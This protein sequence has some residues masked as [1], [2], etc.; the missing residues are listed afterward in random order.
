MLKAIAIDDEPLA[1]TIISNFSE[2]TEGLK[3]EKTFSSQ[4]HALKYIRQYPVDLLF[5]DIHMPKKN[6]IAFYR[7]IDRNLPVIF[8]TAFSEYA[9]EGFNLNAVDYLIKPFS[10]DRFQESI[11]K[12]LQ[13]TEYITKSNEQRHILVRSNYKLQRISLD[14]IMFIQAMDNYVIIFL[15]LGTKVA[16]QLPMKEILSKLPSNE[17]IRIHRSY[18]ISI[19]QITSIGNK[20]VLISNFELPVGDKFRRDLENLLD[21]P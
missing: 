3:L 14:D 18:I 2:R 11:K 13:R 19:P 16:T 7:N 9:V 1:L 20:S 17:F 4:R 12:A 21:Y 15:V 6:G 5:L 10:L 8:T